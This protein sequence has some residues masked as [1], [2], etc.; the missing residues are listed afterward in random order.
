MEKREE[1]LKSLQTYIGKVDMEV[2]MILQ[3]LQWDRSHLLEKPRMVNCKYDAN[4]RIPIEMR[5]AHESQCF[6]NVNGYSQEDLLLP[7]AVDTN[8]GVL[9][10]L[11]KIDINSIIDKAAKADPTFKRGSGC[12][13]AE[14]MSL[15]RLQASYTADERR[16]IYEAVVQAAP[17]CHDL[18]DLALLS[19]NEDEQKM[20][21]QKSRLEILAELRD[22]KRRRTKYRVAAKTQ[23]YSDLLRD[24]IKTQM[25]VY[26]VVKEEQA[27]DK[28]QHKVDETRNRNNDKYKYLSKEQ[29]DK[30]KV[31]RELDRYKDGGQSHRYGHSKYDFDK[32]SKRGDRSDKYYQVNNDDE[33]Y[34]KQKRNS[35]KDT[36]HKDSK[37]DRSSDYHDYSDTDYNTK[38]DRYKRERNNESHGSSDYRTDKATRKYYE[39]AHSSRKHLD[40]NKQSKKVQSKHKSSSKYNSDNEDKDIKPIYIK[41]EYDKYS[42]NSTNKRSSY[43]GKYNN[44]SYDCYEDTKNFVKKRLDR[45]TQ[46]KYKSDRHATHKK[47]SKEDSSQHKRYYDQYK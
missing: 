5:D 21:K 41:Q 40:K 25:E 20:A 19:G 22:M 43:G 33:Y 26:T 3:Q 4:H 34:N 17:S 11:S 24:V 37:R 29:K 38:K 42:E 35:S 15:E 13:G 9:I 39:E 7:D 28:Q 18:T 27:I 30:E 45:S 14:P 44:E 1:D 2:T 10:K 8:A 46:D 23:N 31:Y 32:N 16:A 6:Y 12:E 36:S 47:T